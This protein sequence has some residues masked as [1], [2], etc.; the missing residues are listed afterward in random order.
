MKKN[1]RTEHCRTKE[2]KANLRNSER[3][4]IINEKLFKNLVKQLVRLLA[5]PI[6][7]DK[8][9][10]SLYYIVMGQAQRAISDIKRKYK[11]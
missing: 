1:S 11:I 9:Q 8:R 3:I 7:Y 10:L 6:E 2:K 4:Y 5:S